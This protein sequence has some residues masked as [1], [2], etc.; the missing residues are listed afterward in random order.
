VSDQL[1]SDEQVS[2]KKAIPADKKMSPKVK[3]GGLLKSSAVVAFMTML[4]RIL[5]LVRDVVV[6]VM[7]GASSG[8]DAFFVAFKIPN[9]FRRLFGEGAFA[10]AFVPVLTEYQQKR[11]HDVVK[12][13]V[14]HV[15][16]TLGGVLL[17]T[18]LVAVAAAPLLAMV[19]APGFTNDVDK[20]HL[21]VDMLRLTF[22]YLMLISLAGFAGA[23]LNSYG[24]FAVPAFTPVLLNLSLIGC[25]WL[26]APYLDTP[27]MALAYGVLLAG[28]VQLL[29]QL[30]FL[31]GLGLLPRP[32]YRKQHEGVKQII[33]LMIPALFGVSVSQINLLLDTVL[34][35][36]LQTGSV[37]WLY[38]SD[39]LTEL[40]LGVFGIA[41]ATVILPSLSKKHTNEDGQSFAKT[42]EWAVRMVLLI[43]V[44]AMLA[45]IILAEPLISTLFLHG[46]MTPEDLPMIAASLRAYAL[47]LLAFMLIKVLAPG[48]FSRQD[49]K[50]P[51]KIAIW[52]MVANMVLNLMLVWHLDH[53]GLALATS[54]SSWLNAFLLYFALRKEQVFYWQSGILAYLIRL[55]LAC[56]AMV[57]ALLWLMP[58]G[59]IWLDGSVWQRIYWLASLVVVGGLSYFVVL[60]I[61]G[62]RPRQMR[63]A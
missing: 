61:V 40:P 4:S 1:P 6:A 2:A 22:P 23:I 26:L 8:A 62:L 3:Q 31:G 14:D 38:Y 5:G 60:L 30:P 16:G 52:A 17:V 51:V 29:F 27:V 36:F 21:T 48:F 55:V 39:R 56:A 49:T 10:Q 33:T 63:Q 47:G 11:P 20:Y 50:T 18:S 19:F 45:L 59:S 28:V 7:F 53:V 25:A 32:R 34:A 9:F 54:L 58:D 15:A 35:S 46:E 43:G 37:A 42:L 41:I 12:D 24:R 13:L 57:A 44:P